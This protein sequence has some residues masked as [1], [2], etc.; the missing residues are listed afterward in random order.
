MATQSTPGSLA[1]AS[2]AEEL[3]NQDM[4]QNTR[5]AAPKSGVHMLVG[6]ASAGGIPYDKRG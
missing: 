1:S 6:G 3:V 5:G 2:N 4:C